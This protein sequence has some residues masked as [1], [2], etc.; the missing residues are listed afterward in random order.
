[1]GKSL[2]GFFGAVITAVIVAAAVYFTGGTALAALAWG[3][4]AGAVSLVSTSM[5]SQLGVASYGDVSD[6]LSRSTSP[7]TGLPVIYGGQYPHK[8]GTNG[9]S[10]VL[11]GSIVSWYNVQNN[12]SQYLFSEQA[13][14]YTGTEKYINQIYIDNE[15]VLDSPITQDGIVSNASIGDLY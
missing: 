4:A 7:T 15:P 1:M 3:A 2:G 6:T 9:G 14:A 13:V 5:L 12:S 8:N 10:Y 11:T